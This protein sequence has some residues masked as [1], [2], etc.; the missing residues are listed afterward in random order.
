MPILFAGWTCAAEPLIVDAGLVFMFFF[1]P[2]LL[3]AMQGKFYTKQ[4]RN[5][6]TAGALV[7][8][9]TG[10]FSML[11]FSNDDCWDTFW[12]KTIPGNHLSPFDAKKLT[13]HLII[14]V[15]ILMLYGTLALFWYAN[16]NKK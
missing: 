5:M 12:Q 1:T 11:A 3:I 7:T 13:I 16:N 15:A 10:I 2:A 8:L 9:G 6:C 4:F 14:Y